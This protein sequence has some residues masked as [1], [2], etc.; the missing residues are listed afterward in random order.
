MVNKVKICLVLKKLNDIVIKNKDFIF[1]YNKFNKNKNCNTYN[2]LIKILN[3]IVSSNFPDNISNLIRDNKGKVLYN[4][5]LIDSNTF[6]NYINDKILYD[7]DLQEY[8]SNRAEKCGFYKKICENQGYVSENFGSTSTTG[9]PD[10]FGKINF[11]S[12]SSGKINTVVT[13]YGT[14]LDPNIPTQVSFFDSST[15][16]LIDKIPTLPQFNDTSISFQIPKTLT[17]GLYYFAVEH[18]SNTDFHIIQ[19]SSNVPGQVYNSF[20]PFTVV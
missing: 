15:N 7:S 11:Y 6:F 16:Q 12:P 10:Y 3:K 13:V 19:V 18:L 17:P 2:K 20:I 5:R 1:H 4:S 9:Y 14:R 8:V